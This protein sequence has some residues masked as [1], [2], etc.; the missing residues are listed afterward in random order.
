MLGAGLRCLFNQMLDLDLVPFGLPRRVGCV[1]K[2][3]PEVAPCRADKKT[4]RAGKNAFPLPACKG[5]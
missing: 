4:G 3:A 2:P 1:A 5:F